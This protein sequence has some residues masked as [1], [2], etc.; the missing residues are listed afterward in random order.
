MASAFTSSGALVG[1]IAG[2][3]GD[4]GEAGAGSGAAP[5]FTVTV[6]GTAFPATFSAMD[7][8]QAFCSSHWLLAFF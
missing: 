2:D 7:W 3:V 1:F 4:A 5:A 6:I 8:S